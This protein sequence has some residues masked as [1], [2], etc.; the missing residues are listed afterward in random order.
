MS[1]RK[2]IAISFLAI[3]CVAGIVFLCVHFAILSGRMTFRT[4]DEMLDGIKGKYTYTWIPGLYRTIVI[5]DHKSY[6]YTHDPEYGEEI[7]PITIRYHPGDGTFDIV[8]DDNSYSNIIVL[9]SGDI[10]Y[11]D[12]TYTKLR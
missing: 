5:G 7:T 3:L 12:R 1:K 2:K 4:S 9:K 6:I 8:F 10:I 11:Q